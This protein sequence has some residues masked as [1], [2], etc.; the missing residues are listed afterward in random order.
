MTP[1]NHVDEFPSL[2]TIKIET[3]TCGASIKVSKVQCC[4]YY[5]PLEDSY[6]YLAVAKKS[7]CQKDHCIITA[8]LARKSGFTYVPFFD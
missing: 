7:G 4:S 5:I 8:E 2:N 6:V 3:L 1:V